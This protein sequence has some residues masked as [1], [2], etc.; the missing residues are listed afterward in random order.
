[1]REAENR[2]DKYAVRVEWQGEKLGYLP[3]AENR[4]VAAEMDQGGRVEG[5]IAELRDGPDPWQRVRIEVSV[6]F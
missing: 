3:R 1:M 5:R 4:A 2:H 6:A